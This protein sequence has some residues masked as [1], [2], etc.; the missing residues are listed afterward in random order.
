MTREF[1]EL[2]DFTDDWEDIGFDDDDLAELQKELN[3]D[4]KVGYVMHG[5]GNVRKMRFSY[6]NRGKNRSARI[7]YVDC[8]PEGKVFLIGVYTKKEKENL[9]AQEKTKVRD[10]LGD[11][12]GKRFRSIH[13]KA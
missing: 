13:R 6:G 12:E 8:E 9:S 10:L 7:I 2:E 1:I 4:P 11:I 3:N 5:L